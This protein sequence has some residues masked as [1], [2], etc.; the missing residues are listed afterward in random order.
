MEKIFKTFVGVVISLL[1][2][3]ILIALNLPKTKMTSR[4]DS[5]LRNIVQNLNAD[6]PRAVG[7]IGTLDSITYFNKAISYNMT[8]DGDNGIRQIYLKNYDKF[9]DI[10]KYSI[11]VMN[12]QRNMGNVL[13]S[14]LEAKGINMSVVIYTQNGEST[15]WTI[16]GEELSRF[17]DSCKISPTTALK[18]TIDMEIEIANLNLPV[19]K[20]DLHDSIRSVALNSFLGDIDETCLPQAVSHLDNDIAFEYNVDENAFNLNGLEKISDNVDALEMLASSLINDNADMQEFLGLI[21]ISQS[22][23]VIIYN[24]RT[25]HKK[26]SIRLP[27]C[28]LKKYCKVP[29]CLLS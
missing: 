3:G 19:K 7:T 2:I 25:S 14:L 26:V 17:I 6:L 5:I 20:E 13:I 23:F 18:S 24:G 15:T 29:Q 12:G 21:A 27:Y 9:R 28:I 22:D 4:E 8:V 10:L 16:T 11:L 1:F